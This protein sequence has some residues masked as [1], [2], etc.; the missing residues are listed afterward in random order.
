VNESRWA[1]WAQALGIAASVLPTTDEF[2]CE[3]FHLSPRQTQR[4]I[5]KATMLTG[6]LGVFVIKQIC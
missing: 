1:L 5:A 4:F 3:C 2:P 6:N